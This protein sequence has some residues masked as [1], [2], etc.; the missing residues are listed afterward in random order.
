MSARVPTNGITITDISPPE[1]VD[2]DR[3]IAVTAAHPCPPPQVAVRISHVRSNATKCRTRPDRRPRN[4]KYHADERS[5]RAASRHSTARFG[6]HS[7]PM[8]AA[9]MNAPHRILAQD[10]ATAPLRLTSARATLFRVAH[11]CRPRITRQASP[12]SAREKRLAPTFPGARSD[13]AG[14]P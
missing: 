10:H 6:P 13:F 5:H 14:S 8:V 3:K 12:Q 11:R 7:H 2:P 9:T 1:T 4:N